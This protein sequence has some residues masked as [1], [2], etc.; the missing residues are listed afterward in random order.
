[1]GGKETAFQA[2]KIIMCKSPVVGVKVAQLLCLESS[3]SFIKIY[4]KWYLFYQF[5]QAS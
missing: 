3:C 1:M 5:P 2:E 4:S